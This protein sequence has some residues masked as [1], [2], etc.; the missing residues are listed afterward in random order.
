MN[1]KCFECENEIPEDRR[2]LC[3]DKCDA[4]YYKMDAAVL[5]RRLAR[6]IQ[7]GESYREKLLQF[8]TEVRD[9]ISMLCEIRDNKCADYRETAREAVEILDGSRWV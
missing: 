5:D 2:F 7:N 8:R 4:K 6:A 3:S 1:R 9:V